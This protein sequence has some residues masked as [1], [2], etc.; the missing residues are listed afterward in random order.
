MYTFLIVDDFDGMR[1]RLRVILE[2]VG[3]KVVGEAINGKEAVEKYKAL[4]PDFVTLDITM[5]DVDGLEALEKII[6]YDENAK[7]IMVS[8]ISEKNLVLQAIDKGARH[9]ILKPL[10]AKRVKEI[11]DEVIE[12]EKEFLEFN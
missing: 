3:H 5:P 9:Y 4:K 8:A 6:E 2:E 10:K 12:Y 7:I 11:I 1:D